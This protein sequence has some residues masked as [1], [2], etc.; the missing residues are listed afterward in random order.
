MSPLDIRF[1]IASENFDSQSE[2]SFTVIS[3]KICGAPIPQGIVVPSYFT[4]VS[5]RHE[6][7]PPPF[8]I[9]VTDFGIVT[10]CKESQFKNAFA[11]IVVTFSVK[12]MLSRF[13]QSANILVPKLHISIVTDFNFS[14]LLKTLFPKTRLSFKFSRTRVSKSVFA[15]ALFPI[16]VT[17]VGI[18]TSFKP[19]STKA[20]FSIIFTFSGITIFSSLR[21]LANDNSSIVSTVA[22]SITELRFKHA[23]KT[24]VRNCFYIS[25]DCHRANIITA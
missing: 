1:F 3:F 20:F 14:Q 16:F 25:C 15:N 2:P 10:S 21:H 11:G 6:L 18:T 5:K 4:F 12:I 17:V 22:G 19:E 7:N 13:L 9:L 24:T 23:K 8:S